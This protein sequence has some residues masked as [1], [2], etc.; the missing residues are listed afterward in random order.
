MLSGLC[1]AR[2][3]IHFSSGKFQVLDLSTFY[4]RFRE[5]WHDF[6]YKLGHIECSGFAA[7]GRS[8]RSCKTIGLFYVIIH[9]IRSRINLLDLIIGN[10]ASN[11]C[12]DVYLAAEGFL[13]LADDQRM[14]LLVPTVASGTDTDM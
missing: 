5:F 7:P 8:Q 3:L 14:L 2:M 4:F 13:S 9:F 6:W 10:M 11:D 1:F 12:D